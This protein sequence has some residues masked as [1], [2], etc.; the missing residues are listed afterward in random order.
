MIKMVRTPS[1]TPNITNIDDIIPFRYAYGNQDGFVKGKGNEL[2]YTINGSEFRINSGR[3]V[4][5]GV[6]SDID[7]NGVSINVDSIN[8]KRYY[9]VYYNVNLAT[10]ITSILSVYDTAGF[11]SIDKGDDLTVNSIGNAN[12]ELYQF[13]SN[14][15]VVSNVK[16]VVQALD[17]INKDITVRNSKSVNDLEIKIENDLL[18][19]GDVVVPQKKLIWEG[20]QLLNSD[21]TSHLELNYGQ[22]GVNFGDTLEIYARPNADAINWNQGT[23]GTATYKALATA[24][25]R[26]TVRLTSVTP[27]LPYDSTSQGIHN[28]TEYYFSN[29][30]SL[31]NKYCSSNVFLYYCDLQISQSGNMRICFRY[32][33]FQDDKVKQYA[34]GWTITKIYKIIE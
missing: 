24:E 22:L 19:I 34:G 30:S 20:E 14:N 28:V 10:N 1:E 13:E 32:H 11:P 26:F 7:A 2:S 23:A 25:N 5:Q 27:N 3:I 12:L 33:N 31:I 6:E 21:A 17:Y 15:G 16:K 18:K 4:L 29:Q 9:S 8:E